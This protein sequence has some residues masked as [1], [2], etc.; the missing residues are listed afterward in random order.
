MSTV[1]NVT[2]MNA[3]HQ[4]S[5]TKPYS[6]ATKKLQQELN[7][8]IDQGHLNG[9]KLKEDG[10]EGPKTRAKLQ[11][12]QAF[13][14]A[15]P[16]E[17]TTAVVPAAPQAVVKAPTQAVVPADKNETKYPTV[18]EYVEGQ[19]KKAGQELKE[20]AQVA[21]VTA[22]AAPVV[23]VIEARHLNQA[24][25]R[26]AKLPMDPDG[27]WKVEAK[28][29]FAEEQAAAKKEIL[30]IPGKVADGVVD[31]AVAVKEGVSDAAD[32]VA[33]GIE[34]AAVAL[35]DGVIAVGDGV[36]KA[37]KAVGRAVDAFED[38]IAE[39]AHDLK[40]DAQVVAVTA[41]AP[42]PVA[43]IQGKHLEQARERI[44]K[45]PMD[46]DGKWKVEAKKILA[47]ERAEAK[48]E[49]LALPGKVKD[50]VVDAAVAVKNG[51]VNTAEAVADG[52]SDAATA[53]GKTV[54][55][56][57]KV[58]EFAVEEA[59]DDVKDFANDVADDISKGVKE[60]RKD[61]GGFFQRVGKW[62]AGN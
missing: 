58:A 10:K 35:A 47:E 48:A 54:V 28:K 9:P 15:Q 61:V 20:D 11:E 21:A 51:V 39:M 36:V 3:S 37:G 40:D 30:A 1:K 46:P 16:A 22:I 8:H 44:A 19:I 55:K 38:Q 57:Y 25:E 4:V 7:K 14:K 12:F 53:V 24:R 2:G 43:V 13:T 31:A 60:A 26:V 6:E 41:L 62:I 18:G 34:D 27:K 42:I 33:D 50:G 23:A 52:V 45:L 59:V 17:T 29:I 49:I 5:G 56:G 32:A